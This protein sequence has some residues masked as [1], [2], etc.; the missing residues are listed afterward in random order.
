VL[1]SLTPLALPG[2]GRAE[3]W[4][5]L[6]RV[7]ARA[8]QFFS[9][10]APGAILRD[11]R[12]VV[13]EPEEIRLNITAQLLAY[14]ELYAHTGDPRHL[15][16]VI[17]RADFLV[18][19]LDEIR[20]Y[21]AFDGM[22]GYALLSAYAATGDPAYKAP[23]ETI[24]AR[25]K[26]LAGW[27]NT[28][29]WGLMCAICLSEVHAQAGDE[30]ARTKV[31][32]IINSLR[33]YQN[34]NGSFPHYC[35]HSI[36]VHYTAWMGTEL[37]LVERNLD[38]P[39]IGQ[40]LAGI[41]SFLAERIDATGVPSYESCDHE[42]NCRSYYSRASGCPEDY[43]TRGWINEL[44]YHAVILRPVGSHDYYDVMDFLVATGT[45]G[46]YPDKWDFLPP[47]EDPIHIWATGSP[48]VL[49][50]SLV[51]WL[52]AALQRGGFNGDPPPPRMPPLPPLSLAR[53]PASPST[54]LILPLDPVIL[55]PTSGAPIVRFA[56]PAAQVVHLSIHDVSGRVVRELA[57]SELAAGQHEIAWDGR[58]G[59]G[60]TA[61][62]GIYFCRLDAGHEVRTRKIA[63]VR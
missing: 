23:V 52:M 6:P 40:L 33:T 19:R 12:L 32:A 48:S 46:G 16:A 4:D 1:G 5:P 50:T 22:L 8:E 54:N 35:P 63:L 30:D 27:D 15:E 20:T 11:P 34:E 28:L 13:H 7:L 45:E 49:R 41:R 14:C 39:P 31:I 24:V 57:G 56:L 25:C 36:D 29:N 43:D 53:I 2:E 37:M 62:R 9:L 18:A 51:F 44:A 17:L 58:N 61:A 59:A 26:Q 55:N 21:S 60:A 42:Q 47:A 10:R 38:Y 3:E